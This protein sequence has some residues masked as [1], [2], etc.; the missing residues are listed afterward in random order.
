MANSSE[1][2]DY[3]PLQFR[4]EHE[5]V[6][7]VR[8]FDQLG[9]AVETRVK[10]GLA[11]LLAEI[12]I[13]TVEYAGY[14]LLTYLFPQQRLEFMF[15][16]Q[17]ESLKLALVGIDMDVASGPQP[18][19]Q[20]LYIH[21]GDSFDVKAIAR[22]SPED[23]REG[24]YPQQNTRDLEGFGTFRDHM[25]ILG[26]YAR[27]YVNG[28]PDH[29]RYNQPNNMHFSLRHAVAIGGEVLLPGLYGLYPQLREGWAIPEGYVPELLTT[30]FQLTPEDATWLDYHVALANYWKAHQSY[31]SDPHAAFLASLKE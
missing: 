11:D 20:D 6:P 30:M 29:D 2:I 31:P 24:V 15:P 26:S 1:A 28:L 4:A 16:E 18:N 14:A 23:W 3:L 27:T 7:M 5:L 19:P 22:R 13:T 8:D 17:A 9:D 21:F 10:P 25:F 12:D